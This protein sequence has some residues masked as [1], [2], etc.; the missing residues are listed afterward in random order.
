M[1]EKLYDHAK[2]NDLDILDEIKKGLTS[3]KNIKA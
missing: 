1:F 3:S 2:F